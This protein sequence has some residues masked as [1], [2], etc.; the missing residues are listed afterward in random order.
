VLEFHYRNMKKKWLIKEVDESLLP[1]MPEYPHLVA[2]L[3][4]LRGLTQPEPIQEFLNPDYNKLHDPFLFKDM[5]R[6]IERIR[7]ALNE[8]QKIII[9][10][11]Y[12][13]DAITAAS[14]M[15][16]GLRKLGGIVDCYIPDRFTE[17]YG[18][19]LDAIKKVAEDGT[20]LMITVDCGTNSVAEA[21][22]CKELGMD[23]IITDHHEIT[24]SLPDAYTL[25]NPKNPEDRYPFR[26]LTGVGVAFKVIQ[27][28]YQGNDAPDTPA[29]WEK[30]LLDIVSIGTVA[31]LQTL[32]GE[33]RILVHY[34]LQVLNKTRWPGVRALLEVSKMKPGK[35]TTHTL[36][37]VLAP[38]INAAGRIKH[39]DVAYK[40]LI[41]EN[42]L[43]AQNYALE[44]DSL[45]THRQML[46]ERILSEAREQVLPHADRKV[47]LAAGADW[48][49]GVVGLVAGKLAEEFNR[50][51]LVMDK[52]PEF[53]TGSARS[54]PY[55]D[56]V[57]A[58]TA[59][60]DL[61]EK[62]GGHTQAAGFTL[63]SDN[64]D[65]LYKQLLEF[66][67][68]LNE[69]DSDPVLELD[70]VMTAG[71]YNWDTQEL[72]EKFEP[73]GFGNPRPKFAGY[74]LQVIDCRTVGAQAQHLK[75]K[76]LWDGKVVDAIGFRQGFWMGKITPSQMVDIAFEIESNEWNGHKDLQMKIIDIKQGE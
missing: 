43:E 23:L 59:S 38:R 70:A 28:L 66:A 50:P 44:L 15:A 26:Y 55:F 16:L 42:I 45:N 58:L 40:M 41:S 64:I 56:I 72:I 48:P 14:I 3:L 22:L 9:Y 32:E 13:A 46:T 11:D 30:W 1:N 39:A 2:R 51:V 63:R 20:K 4:A 8:K 29:G 19:N 33:N 35:F 61:L 73:F 37:F 7:T 67:D 49:K 21:V 62:Y 17:G 31:D 74:G 65:L 36:G 6:S 75:L 60:K 25:I 10:A 54:F 12:D 68:T 27:A 57:K 53:A 34:G 69:T 76:L 52:G 24:G 71:E 18:M 5:A 47:L